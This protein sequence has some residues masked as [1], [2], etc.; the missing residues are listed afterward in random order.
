MNAEMTLIKQGGLQL[1]WLLSILPPLCGLSDD[2]LSAQL[3]ILRIN[4]ITN[5]AE[6]FAATH[7]FLAALDLDPVV[8]DA[9]PLGLISPMRASLV[10]FARDHP[11]AVVWTSNG[12]TTL[13]ELDSSWGEK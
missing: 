10:N 11:D 3:S 12:K 4:G 8:L 2:S 5:A 9:L 13:R 7:A 6:L 1:E